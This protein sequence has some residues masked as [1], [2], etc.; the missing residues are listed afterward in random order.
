MDDA[1][2][3]LAGFTVEPGFVAG[4][5]GGLTQITCAAVSEWTISAISGSGISVAQLLRQARKN[6]PRAQAIIGHAVTSA[7][8]PQ[9]LRSA[10]GN[11]RSGA[12]VSVVR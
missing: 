9:N 1:R 12:A 11:C 7:I 3:H 6:L 8:V 5:A 2:S 4:L 10:Q